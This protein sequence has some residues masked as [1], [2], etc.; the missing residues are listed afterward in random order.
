[1]WNLILQHLVQENK[2]L[3]NNKIFPGL[4]TLDKN[5]LRIYQ[6]Y[7]VDVWVTDSN[8]EDSTVN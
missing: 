8:K 2:I 7:H 3:D 1:M 6:N 5:P 4:K